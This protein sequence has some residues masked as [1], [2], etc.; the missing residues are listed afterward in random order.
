MR[1]AADTLAEAL[2][3]QETGVR[4]Y[5]LSADPQDL[6]P[7][8]E[9][10]RVEQEQLAV[11]AANPRATAEVR[12]QVDRIAAETSAWRTRFA[13]PAIAA[14]RAGDRAG[15]EAMLG[16]AGQPAVPGGPERA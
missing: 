1:T 10:V 13:E 7:Y 9:G 4:G 5:V 14:V 15:A 16:D 2:V 11:I 3:D 8:T 6:V 12:A